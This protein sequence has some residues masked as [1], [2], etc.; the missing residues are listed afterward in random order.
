MPARNRHE[1]GSRG[2]E[3]VLRVNSGLLYFL[4]SKKRAYFFLDF[5]AAFFF[6]GA[7]FLAA[8][9]VAFLAA[10]FLVAMFL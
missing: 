7:A 4:P 3:K 1:Q 10:F 2:K 9:L 6:L 5:L 8:F